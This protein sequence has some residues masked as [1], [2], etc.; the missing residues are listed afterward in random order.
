M[1]IKWWLCILWRVFSLSIAI[2]TSGIYGSPS[3]SRPVGRRKVLKLGTSQGVGDLSTANRKSSPRILSHSISF[4][5]PQ[6]TPAPVR[7]YSSPPPQI[8]RPTLL[9]R[10]VPKSQ[11]DFATL[12]DVSVT[13]SSGDFVVRVKRDFYGFEADTE[14]L[15]L[16]STCKSNGVLMPYGDLL[17]SYP[18]MECDGK[19]QMPPGYLIYTYVLHYTPLTWFPRRAH[20]FNVQVECRFQRYHHVNQ[21][22]V[23]PTWET[24]TGLKKLKGRVN[25][26]IQLMD[27]AWAMPAKSQVYM[28]GQTINFQV[29][30][31]NL[32]HG[33]KLFINHCYATTSKDRKTSLKFTVIDN[34][35]CMLESQKNPG[36]SQFV[37]PRTDD[38]LR[39]FLSAFQFTSDPDTPVFLH[40]KLHVTSEETGPIHKSCTYQ[41][42]RWKAVMGEDSICDCCDSKCVT[43]KPRRSMVK[44]FA[45]SGP[46]LLLDQPSAP[47]GGF[48]PVSPSL[49]EDTVWFE[50]KMDEFDNPD[51]LE[52]IDV[53]KYCDKEE[54]Y[55]R[56]KEDESVPLEGEESVVQ[57]VFRKGEIFEG[58][59]GSGVRDS[60]LIRGEGS[61]FR[62]EGTGLRL[63]FPW[64]RAELRERNPWESK[65]SVLTEEG[66]IERQWMHPQEESSL[67]SEMGGM[68]VSQEE[69]VSQSMEE[70]GFG[71]G[72]AQPL[73][74][75]EDEGR[76][77]RVESGETDE[78]DKTFPLFSETG[79]EII[80][81]YDGLVE[82]GIDGGKDLPGVW[83]FK[84]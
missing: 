62:A 7:I 35:G 23:R 28:L 59:Q 27:D 55:T 20:R 22:V 18:L 3:V 75:P 79:E 45:S 64:E 82:S 56:S 50:T 17:F 34:F 5:T 47:K 83:H 42:N 1:K 13:C 38:T 2:S 76:E 70:W 16:G 44:G 54:G 80:S 14:E 6:L 32:S 36:G 71:V 41:E 21:L 52:T 8:Q 9:D 40:C 78:D 11:R 24:H 69:V 33:G 4:R 68:S 46:L 60:E 84:W 25:F 39:F 15:T 29:S 81:D 66:A 19:R 74:I 31:L 12:P 73:V 58:T 53:E 63:E 48:P 65:G 37:S 43:P 10:P 67:G 57:T 72:E 49:V 51:L 26:R 77:G 61:G 30:A